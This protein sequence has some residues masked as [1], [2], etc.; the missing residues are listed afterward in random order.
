M[1]EILKRLAQL[2][3]AIIKAFVEVIWEVSRK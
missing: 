1:I 3:K 2:L